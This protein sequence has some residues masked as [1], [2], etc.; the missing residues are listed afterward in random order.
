MKEKDPI[1][2][3]SFQ[4]SLFFPSLGAREEER[5]SWERG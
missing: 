5:R 4:G 1:E 2:E 3:T